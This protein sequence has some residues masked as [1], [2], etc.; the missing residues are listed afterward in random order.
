MN[1]GTNDRVADTYK[2]WLLETRAY[3]S[4]AYLTHLDDRRKK[5]YDMLD[6]DGHG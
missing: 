5:G 2:G 3:A 4:D 1:D 6:T